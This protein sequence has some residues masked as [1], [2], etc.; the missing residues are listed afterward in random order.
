MR[1]NIGSIDKTRVGEIYAPLFFRS[2]MCSERCTDMICLEAEYF[3]LNRILLQSIALWPFQQSK[4]V[5]IQF[6]ITTLLMSKFTPKFA[7]KAFSCALF[8]TFVVI[9]YSSF[10]LNIDTLK[11]MMKRLHCACTNLRDK[12]E[13][14]IIQK[15]GRNAKYSTAVLII[16][17]VIA[18]SAFWAI[19]IAIPYLDGVTPINGCRPHQLYIVAEYFIDQQKYYYVILLHM[20]AALFIGILTLIAMGTLLIAYLQHT[21]GMFRIACYRIERALQI[22]IEKDIS[23]NSES[24]IYTKLVDAIHIHREAM[25]LSEHLIRRFDTMYFCLT[26]L[27]VITISLNLF[28]ILLSSDNIMETIVPIISV[29]VLILYVFFANFIG[30]NVTDHNN[31]VYTAAY[32]IRWYM[33]PIH[34]QRLILLLLQRKA[35]EFHLTC[36]GMFVASFDCLATSIALWPFQQSKLVRIQFIVSM[37]ILVGAI[38]YQITT[39]LTSKFTPK[40]VIKAFSCI[41]FFT[42]VVIHYGSFRLNIQTLKD[43]MKQLH[44]ACINL[45]DKNEIAIIQKYG[46]NAKYYTAALIVFFVIAKSAFWASQIIIPYLDGITPINGCRPHQLYIVAEYF[47]DQQKYYYVILLHMNAALFIG[48]LTLIAMGTLLIAYL[49]HTCGMFKIACYRIEHA[50]E[51]NIEKD[52]S[53]NSE[54]SISKKIVY[55]VHIHR[56]AM[57]TTFCVY[58]LSEHL[59]SRFDTMY[60]CLTVLVVITMS[61]NLFQILLSSDSIMEATVPSLNLLILSLY[62]FFAN[63]FGQNVIDHNNEVYA[64]A[65]NIRWYMCPIHVQRLILLLLQR[66]AREFHLTCGGLFIASFDCLATMAKATLSYFTLMHS[67]RQ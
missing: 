21:C 7:I 60:F 23:G 15:Y 54:S 49:Q 25:K 9:H 51:I 41:L 32:N 16:F 45:R 47:I 5:R 46:R 61:L 38:I 12:N 22:N 18:K 4:L 64:A 59:I 3:N 33:C 43:M 53:G 42:L 34:V 13:I 1:W 44:C 2:H 31:E 35:R 10:R 58:R 8:F 67:A 40:F 20:N 65:Y 6:I 28:Q 63:F 14:A 62:V 50:M 30:Q 11:D 24:S 48:I 66:K 57:D 17:F 39:I 27:V 26:V 55:A 56:E 52:I 29:V 37:T 19:Q 36:G